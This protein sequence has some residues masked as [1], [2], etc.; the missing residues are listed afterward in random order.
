MEGGIVAVKTFEIIL[1]VTDENGVVKDEEWMPP[2]TGKLGYYCAACGMDRTNADYDDD[3]QE[4]YCGYCK[5]L[6]EHIV[7]VEC[8]ACGEDIPERDFL[9]HLGE[10]CE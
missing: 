7:I 3:P 4:I 2:T 5:A 10:G 6:L 9:T 8:P 1:R